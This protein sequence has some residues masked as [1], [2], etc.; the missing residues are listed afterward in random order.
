MTYVAAAFTAIMSLL[1][2]LVIANRPL[3]AEEIAFPVLIAPRMVC[4]AEA[5]VSTASEKPLF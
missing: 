3:A 5:P 1:R 4:A 2:L